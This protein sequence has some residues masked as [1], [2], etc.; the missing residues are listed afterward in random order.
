MKPLHE[1]FQQL[2]GIKPL[3]EQNDHVSGPGCASNDSILM[4]ITAPMTAVG[5]LQWSLGTVQT[6]CSSICSGGSTGSSTEEEVIEAC[7]CCN[8]FD[9]VSDD[10]PTIS[11]PSPEPEPEPESEPEPRIPQERTD[12]W[13]N[14]LSFEM[15]EKIMKSFSRR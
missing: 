9:G 3:Y 13:W 15:K 6:V 14:G 10:V 11:T 2:A 7:T 1:R 12:A 8:E 5:G 4:N